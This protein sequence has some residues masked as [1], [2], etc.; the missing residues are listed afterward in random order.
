[1][2]VALIDSVYHDPKAVAETHRPIAEAISRRDE[3]AAQA[4]VRFRYRRRLGAC[5]GGVHA[6][7]RRHRGRPPMEYAL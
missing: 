2:I 1:M 3:A 4:A 7:T 6:E 5:P